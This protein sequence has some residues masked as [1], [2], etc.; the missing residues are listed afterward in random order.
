[1]LLARAHCR[2]AH[3]N[4][5]SGYKW[6]AALLCKHRSRSVVCLSPP[7]WLLQ[8]ANSD[9]SCVHSASTRSCP[10]RSSC[11]TSCL[12]TSLPAWQLRQLAQCNLASGMSRCT[13]QRLWP[14]EGRHLPAAVSA[15][16]NGLVIVL[17]NKLPSPSES[18]GGGEWL[19]HIGRGASRQTS[20]AA[21]TLLTLRPAA[22][23]DCYCCQSA[24]QL[25]RDS[26]ATRQQRPGTRCRMLLSCTA[27][28]RRPA[29][30]RFLRGN[31]ATE[32]CWEG[33]PVATDAMQ[34][35]PPVPAMWDYT[36]LA[37]PQCLAP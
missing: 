18:S 30:T 29:S 15:E 4:M 10:S 8:A 6:H 13:C 37:G 12:P 35:R 32:S 36:H 22:D 9:T 25:L 24:A 28:A 31:Q 1:M 3:T 19:A 5:C 11:R 14:Q 27:A 34:Q 2:P 20:P 7:C 33:R 17:A 16:L 26:R 23:R 21:P